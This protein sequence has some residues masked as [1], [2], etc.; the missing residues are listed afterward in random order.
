M[1]PYTR[2]ENLCRVKLNRAF[3]SQKDV[4]RDVTISKKR[5]KYLRECVDP[6]VQSLKV[7]PNTDDL[8]GKLATE[9]EKVAFEYS[10]KAK[11]L[12]EG[13]KTGKVAIEEAKV[14]EV[15]EIE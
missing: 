11:A 4:I 3:N 12:L 1:D 14:E 5:V 9:V 2:F 13:I 8:K 15:K 6:A 7:I 10:V